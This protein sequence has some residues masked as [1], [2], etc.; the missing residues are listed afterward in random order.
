MRNLIVLFLL[1]ASFM[2][3][4]QWS[5][6]PKQSNL[7]FLSTKKAQITET[8]SF[9]RFDASID[10]NNQLKV[11]IDL[12]SVDTKIPIRDQRMQQKLFNVG[13][14]PKAIISANV[15]QTALALKAGQSQNVTLALKLDL[16][17]VSQSLNAEVFVTRISEDKLL[18]NTLAPIMLDSRNFQLS[19]GIETLKK[20]AGLDSITFVVPV[21]FNVVF[22]K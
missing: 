20:L 22:Q 18:V 16:H 17:G 9:S 2:A 5:L 1:F 15:P 21:T 3:N 8:H 10:K 11:E 14:H 12:T 4:A 13:L 19:S 6:E 7:Y